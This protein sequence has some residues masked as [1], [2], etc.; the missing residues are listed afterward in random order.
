LAKDIPTIAYLIVGDGPDRGRLERKAR[1]LGVEER[2][3]FAGRISE[4]EKPDHYR[5]ADAYVMPSSGEGFGIVYLEALACGIPVIGSKIDGSR[6]ALRDG[7]LGILINPRDNAE[8]RGAI[9]KTLAE[10]GS[11]I[12]SRRNGV[13]YFSTE[14]FCQRVFEIIDAITTNEVPEACREMLKDK[15]PVEMLKS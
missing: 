13:E 11:G 14:R 9:L 1:D 2:V 8:L 4:E 7:R 10:K 6:D 3:I 12:E 5:L 15:V